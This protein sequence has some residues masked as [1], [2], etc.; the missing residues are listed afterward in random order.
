LL[1]I[2]GELLQDHRRSDG[3]VAHR[4]DDLKISSQ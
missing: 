1:T 3:A 2:G 4:R